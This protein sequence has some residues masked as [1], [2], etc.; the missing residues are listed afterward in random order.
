MTFSWQ[1][2]VRT[3]VAMP[4]FYRRHQVHSPRANIAASSP[5]SKYGSDTRRQPINV[6]PGNREA[7]S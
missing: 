5:W 3:N 6:S 2:L 4:T 1:V 7:A